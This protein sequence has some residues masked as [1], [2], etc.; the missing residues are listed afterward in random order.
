MKEVASV[1]VAIAGGG[2][3]GL[4]AAAAI[5]RALP[6]C[7]VKARSLSLAENDPDTAHVLTFHGRY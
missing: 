3:G 2:P 7:T 6:D 5:V 4:A 1:D